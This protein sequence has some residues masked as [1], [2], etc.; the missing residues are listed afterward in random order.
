M[1]RQEKKIAALLRFSVGARRNSA[2]REERNLT[3][4]DG[5]DGLDSGGRRREE[6]VVWRGEGRIL[7]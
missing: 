6:T 2:E 1:S 4:M 5:R 7:A 3:M